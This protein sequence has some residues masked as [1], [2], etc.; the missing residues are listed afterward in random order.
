MRVLVLGA[1]GFVNVHFIRMYET[2]F[3]FTLISSQGNPDSNIL[4]FDEFLQDP[5]FRESAYFDAVV[6]GIQTTASHEVSEFEV[7]NKFCEYISNYHPRLVIYF[8]TGG[9]YKFDSFCVTESSTLKNIYDMN[10]YYKTNEIED[11]QPKDNN[12]AS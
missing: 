12:H 3:D 7:I 4:S 11:Q 1:N 9:L 2:I 10:E 5:I 8:S 6:I